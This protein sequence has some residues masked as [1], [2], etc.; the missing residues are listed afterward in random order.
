MAHQQTADA[1]P[2][3]ASTPTPQ[4][5]TADSAT[6]PAPATAAVPNAASAAFPAPAPASAAVPAPASA[7]VPA[8]DPVHIR[9]VR[10][11][12]LGC[13]AIAWR[14]TLPAFRSC[15][16]TR[17]T[18]VAS[19][20]PAKAERFATEFDCAATGYEE[21]LARDDVDAVYLPLPP[22][23]H[24][25]W[26]AKVLAAGKHLLVEKPIAT[27]AAE[28]RELVHRAKAAGLVL[29]ENFTFS[30]HPQHA[31]IARLIATGRFGTVRALSGEFCFPPLPD[32]D[33]RYVPELGGGALLDAGVYP[34]RAAQLLFG[35]AL[36]VA[37]ASL[38]IDPNHKVD[39]AGQALLVSPQDVLV[40]VHFGFEHTYSSTYSLVGSAASL[41]LDRAFAPPPDFR[42]VL[43][44]E[45]QDHSEQITL[46]PADQ[47]GLAVRSFAEAI[48]AGRAASDE[49]EAPSCAASVRTLE[50][51]DEIR[52]VAVRR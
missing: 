51:V 19:R 34:I 12:V 4:A 11:G 23:L 30:H 38:R 46:R 27:D 48:L 45:E 17:I 24:L 2:A 5:S 9:T 31:E 43:S 10:I 42:P 29:R 7:T 41:S 39:V 18:A 52:R 3:L 26:G 20:D 15:P 40:S 21:L 22:A 28:A 49:A 36:E 32:T 1:P 47:F 14:R 8:T 50:L 33:I 37:G 44:I 6:V 13:S 35:D 16:Q 25:E